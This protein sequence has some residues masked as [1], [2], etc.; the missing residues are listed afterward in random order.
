MRFATYEYRDRRHVAV[1][2]EDGTLYPF[3]ASAR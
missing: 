2:D 1:V 3:P